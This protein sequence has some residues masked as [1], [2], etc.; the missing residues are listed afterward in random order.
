LRATRF[1]EG[2]WW[3]PVEV[4]DGCF[5]P[6]AGEPAAAARLGF[7]REIEVMR[8]NFGTSLGAGSSTSSHGTHS[9][10]SGSVTGVFKCSCSP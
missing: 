4:L 10:S 9:R 6:G 2:A 1:R 8:R 7:Q 5:S 3:R